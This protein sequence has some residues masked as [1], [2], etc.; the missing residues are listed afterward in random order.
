MWRVVSGVVGILFGAA[1]T[2]WQFSAG[3]DAPYDTWS[4]SE[5]DAMEVAAATL[6]YQ[7]DHELNHPQAKRIPWLVL[8]YG[9]MPSAE[10]AARFEKFPQLITSYGQL[11]RDQDD[12]ILF[13]IDTAKRV[14]NETI[15]VTGKVFNGRSTELT[16][17]IADPTRREV[18]QYRVVQKDGLLEV[19][20]ASP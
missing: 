5:Q 6:Q 10:F 7:I 8:V 11:K 9:D 4:I 15:L 12:L 19:A 18:T 13:Q 14:D 2:F 1:V 16:T 20:E 17:H 3:P